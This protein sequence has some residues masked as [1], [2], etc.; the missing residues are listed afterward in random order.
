MKRR[1]F[2]CRQHRHPYMERW[3]LL[4]LLKL[5]HGNKFGTQAGGAWRILFTLALMPWLRKYRVYPVVEELGNTRHG[6]NDSGVIPTSRINVDIQI[7]QQQALQLELEDLRADRAR[8]VELEME[9]H[10]LR[11]LI[12]Q[13]RK[14]S[15]DHHSVYSC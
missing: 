11:V 14:S 2:R 12:E 3:A 13:L 5:R 9:N 7:A 1:P 8:R 15:A 4:Y 6:S 10:N